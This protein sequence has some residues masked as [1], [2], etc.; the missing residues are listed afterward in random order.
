[1]ALAMLALPAA[2][3][4]GGT[5]G[6]DAG[7][8]GDPGLDVLIATDTAE[9][10]V[11]VVEAPP[12]VAEVPDEAASE[13]LPE[14]E[15]AD[16]PAPDPDP[17]P[18][19]AFVPTCEA[20]VGITKPGEWTFFLAGEPTAL[21]AHVTTP[22]SPSALS[23]RWETGEGAP[24]ATAG[25]DAS[26]DS[27]TTAGIPPGAHEIVARVTNA[28]GPCAGDAAHLPVV[29]CKSLLED[30][31]D[32]FDAGAWKVFQ[33]ASWDAGGWIEMTGNVADHRGAIY[34]VKDAILSGSVSW[35]FRFAVGGGGNPM[36]GPGGDGM[37]ATILA[38]TSVAELETLIGQ[39]RKGG[40]L[41]YGLSGPYGSFAGN[42]MTVEIDTWR[43]D[44]TVSG[45]ELH[46]D[47]T[48]GAHVAVTLDGNPGNHLVWIDAPGIADLKW[49]D[50]RVEFV[51]T[52]V[53]VYLDGAKSIDTN[54]PGIDFRGGYL[55]FSG[56]TGWAWEYNRFDDVRILHDCF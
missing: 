3:A 23:V 39:A 51:G 50:L 1:M 9:A 18:D 11:E 53:R 47:P 31:F 46:T 7:P 32:T 34:D 10:A 52:T 25:V 15:P 29:V 20:S 40:G 27:T 36:G 33:D 8:T 38:V 45:D 12:D 2:L 19:E 48:Y 37:A 35:A 55:F 17:G 24:I 13:P 54:V 5:A 16:L 41:G 49:H 43:N 42:A 21:S 26:G 44:T 28:D 4:C 30:D 56:S 22:G 14:I 6:P